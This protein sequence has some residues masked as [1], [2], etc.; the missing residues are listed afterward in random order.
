MPTP[1]FIVAIR[2]LVG[3]DLLWLSGVTGVVFDDRVLLTR[4]ADTGRWALVSGIMEPGEQPGP[5]LAREVTEETGVVVT[6]ERLVSVLSL[7]PAVYPNGDQVQ[8]LDLT[9]ACRRVSGTARVADEENLEVSW[10]AASALPELSPDDRDRIRR[11]GGV[12]RETYFE[13]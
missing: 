3:H 2:R 7:N 13:R 8:F 4:R 9:F 12:E 1:D 10:F 6:V 5:A 11:A